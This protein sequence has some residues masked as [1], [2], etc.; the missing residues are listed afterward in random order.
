[1]IINVVS[2]LRVKHFH[3][4]CSYQKT[5]M[6][7]IHSLKL[8]FELDKHIFTYVGFSSFYV[9]DYKVDALVALRLKELS[10]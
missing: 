1:M 6:R 4:C 2:E 9:R 10:P 7:V 3:M 8:P 5:V